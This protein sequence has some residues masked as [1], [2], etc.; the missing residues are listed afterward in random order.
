MAK[1]SI[2]TS[3]LSEIATQINVEHEKA[4]GAFQSGFEHALQAGE[5]LLQA[6]AKVGHGNWLRWLEKHCDAS[7]RTARLY[8]QVARGR[9]ILESKSADFADLTLDG[10]IK[11]LAIQ[12]TPAA[13]EAAGDDPWAIA[14]AMLD[15]PFTPSDFEDG[16]AWLH[17]KLTHQADLPATVGFCLGVERDYEVPALRLCDTSELVEATKK[18]APLANGKGNV[19]FDTEEFSVSD[20][21]HCTAEL[22]LRAQLLI[23]ACLTELE[24]WARTTPE[25]RAAEWSETHTEMM[26]AIDAKLAE[27]GETRAAESITA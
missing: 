13:V 23:G 12:K 20:L 17:V 14:E 7:E 21:H 24:R 25:R 15:G 4:I 26:A 6:K 10:A 11:L 22:N 3:S 27:L 1:T 2:A 9:S 16:G 5:F 19:A 8:M 18:L